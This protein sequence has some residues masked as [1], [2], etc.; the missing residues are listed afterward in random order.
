[1]LVPPGIGG[2]QPL[3]VLYQPGAVKTFIAQIGQKV[4]Q[5][6]AAHEPAREAHGIDAF[7]PQPVRQR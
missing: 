1:M 4:D 5:R 6:G 2:I 3:E 7:L